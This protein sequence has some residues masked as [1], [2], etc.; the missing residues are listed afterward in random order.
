MCLKHAA[1]RAAV[2]DEAEL[3][4]NCLARTVDSLRAS[5]VPCARTDMNELFVVLSPITKT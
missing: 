5:G 4:A 2:T 3:A 1:V